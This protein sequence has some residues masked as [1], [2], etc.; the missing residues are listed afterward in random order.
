[1]S[2][3][4]I[5]T[6]KP[7]HTY[8]TKLLHVRLGILCVET[9][10]GSVQILHVNM[11]LGTPFIARFIR[12]SF[13]AEGNVIPRHSHPEAM[14][15]ITYLNQ[16]MSMSTIHIAA[17]RSKPS[18]NYDDANSHPIRIAR[19]TVLKPHREHYVFVTITVLF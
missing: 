10:F 8:G 4:H 19:Q 12:K 1:M 9:W 5:E 3:F 17:P 11:L 2:Q 16:R 18:N 13:P 14:L 6:Q 15:S 7:L